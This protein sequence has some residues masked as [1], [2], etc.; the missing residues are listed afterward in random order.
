[1]KINA[2][3][4]VALAAL[5]TASFSGVLNTRA[6]TQGDEATQMMQS[7]EQEQ[8][9]EAAAR[10]KDATWK[11]SCKEVNLIQIGSP[12]ALKNFCLNQDGNI[13]ACYAGNGRASDSKNASGLRVYSPKG[14]LLKTMPLELNPD[15]VCVATDGSIFAA[16]EGRL[17]KLDA[18]GKVLASAESPVAKLP[19]AINKEVE[20]MVK[21]MAKQTKRPFEQQLAEMK[22]QLEKRRG[23]V[24]GL[25]VTEQDVFMAVPSPNDFSYRVYRFTHALTGPSLV[26][27]KLR[28][29]CA[30]MDIQSHEGK[31]WIPHNARH[32]VESHDRD[33]KQLTSFGKAGRVKASDFGGCC[34][35]KNIRVLADGDILA[36]ESGPPTCIKRFSS[37]GK[38][39]EVIAVVDGAKGD[40]VR[41]TVERSSDGKRYYMLDTTRGAIHVFAAKS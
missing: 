39:K 32:Q 31:L 38:F 7:Y 30:Q 34:E 37:D 14:E 28:G 9:A 2:R 22:T 19:V 23:D 18:T 27:D 11:P 35:P 1:M 26:V 17:L 5:L 36:A 8:R 3:W 41:V 10:G 29:C 24:T 4:I 6:A 25:T 15:A 16:G 21:E 13:L 12:G 33:G 20:D 40:C